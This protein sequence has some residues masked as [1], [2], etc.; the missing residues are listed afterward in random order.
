MI[1]LDCRTVEP[2]ERG[3]HDAV[4][5]TSGTAGGLVEHLTGLSAPVV[6]ALDHYE[7]FRLMD[8]WLRQDLAPVLPAGAHLVLAGR[9]PPVA[10]WY[11]LGGDFQTLPLGPLGEEDAQALLGPAR[12]RGG[13]VTR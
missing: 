9:V 10:A 2:T 12:R 4:V 6:L 13:G 5:G 3:F 11:S 8:T 7:L 1:A